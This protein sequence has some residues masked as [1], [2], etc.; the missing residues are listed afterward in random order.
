[1]SAFRVKFGPHI[2]EEKFP[3]HNF[4]ASIAEKVAMGPLKADPLAMVWEEDKQRQF[5]A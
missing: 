4:D 2:P 3:A 1:M 5:Q